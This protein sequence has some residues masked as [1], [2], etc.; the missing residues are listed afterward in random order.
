MEFQELLEKR[1]SIRKYDEALVEPGD[2]EKIISSAQKA[3]SWKNSQT[4]RYYAAISKQAIEAIREALPAFNQNNSMNASYIIASYKTGISGFGND[5]EPT[6]EGD[7]WGAYDLGLQNACLI[8]K[9]KELGYDT[10]IMGLRDEKMI[11][12]YFAIPE[13]ETI[14]P[15][16]AIGKS[17]DDPKAR[18]RKDLSEILKVL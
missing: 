14:M 9:A 6:E 13:D 12:E 18:P 10:L 16:I 11:R 5:G 4:G 8:L 1:K 17:E 7:K 15:V 3:P 2:L